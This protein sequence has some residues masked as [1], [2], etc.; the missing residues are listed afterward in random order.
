M[1]GRSS[2]AITEQIRQAS[3]IVDVISSYVSLTRAGSTLKAL[4]PFHQ[5]RSPS[6]IVNPAKQ[7]F[8]CFGCGAGGDVF[9]FIQLRENVG[10]P[11]ARQILAARAGISLEA[12]RQDRSGPDSSVSKTELERVNRWALRW[13]QKQLTSAPGQRAREYLESR[14]L[15]PE[16]VDRFSVGAAPDRWDALVGAASS[17][18]IAP[19][20][21]AAAGLVKVNPDTGST[22]DAFRNRLIFPILDPLGRVIGFGGRTLGDDPAKY[23]NSPKTDL[24]D[25]SRCLYGLDLAKEAFREHRTAVVV[26]GYVDCVM[27]HQFGFHQPVATLGSALTVDHVRTLRRYVDA[28]ILVFDSDEAGQKA[29]DQSLRFFLRERL[30]VR[31][32]RVPEAKD[33][34]DLLLAAGGEAFQ[35]VLTSAEGALQFKW[36]QVFRR[37][38]NDASPA[39]QRAA[40]EEFISAVASSADLDASD[41]I[42]RGLLLNQVAKLVGLPTEVVHRQCRIAAKASAVA[43]SSSRRAPGPSRQG[44]SGDAAAAALVELLGVLLNEPSYF[45]SVESVLDP[46]LIKEAETRAIAV[47]MAEMIRSTGEVPLPQL[48]SRFDAPEIARR[49]LDLHDSA[50]AR[51]NFGA[52][53]EGAVRCLQVHRAAACVAQMEARLLA[54]PGTVAEQAA[55]A[56]EAKTASEGTTEDQVLAQAVLQSA[57]QIRRFAARRHAGDSIPNLG[58]R[59]PSAAG[60]GKGDA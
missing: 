22:Y 56:P 7:I 29:A 31:I 48:I 8:K 13:F 33:P 40:V 3:D 49:I 9:K 27:A 59:G 50:V 34:A 18:G 60:A 23:I 28:V 10:F 16:I 1:A 5:E 6:F 47:A 52:T 30:E 42:Q 15:S 57:R 21:L 36:S 41:P 2:V 25:K 39:S 26:E 20:L 17:A 54:S 46:A 24:F 43:Q 38:R 44:I 55:A 12:A 45:A 19:R 32:A 4:C 37:Y 35:R 53:V 14:G 51:G 11:E 58:T